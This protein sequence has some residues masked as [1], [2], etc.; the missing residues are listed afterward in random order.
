MTDEVPTAV[1]PA[2]HGL[3]LMYEDGRVFPIVAF[4]R[5]TDRDSTILYLNENRRLTETNEPPAIGM[6]EAWIP[7]HGVPIMFTSE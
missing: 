1:I 3:T 7:T 2:P 4:N 5:Y 6:S